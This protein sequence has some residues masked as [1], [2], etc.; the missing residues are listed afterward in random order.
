MVIVVS[1]INGHILHHKNTAGSVKAGA[2]N[3]PISVSCFTWMSGDSYRYTKS[4][5]AGNIAGVGNINGAITIGEDALW[6]AY[7]TGRCVGDNIGDTGCRMY[8]GCLRTGVAKIHIR[9]GIRACSCFLRIKI[10]VVTIPVCSRS[11]E[12]SFQRVGR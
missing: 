7:R 12:I 9:D 10:P 4:V 11:G 3:M 5:N 6:F 1:N 2:V 8:S